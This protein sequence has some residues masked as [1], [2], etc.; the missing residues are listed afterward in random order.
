MSQVL[1][2]YTNTRSC[3]SA[4]ETALEVES[5]HGPC[6]FILALSISPHPHHPNAGQLCME[7]AEWAASYTT[8]RCSGGQFRTH[9]RFSCRGTEYVGVRVNWRKRDG[10]SGGNA[11]R[12]R[13][14]GRLI[15]NYS[16]LKY[17]WLRW[18]PWLQAW[19]SSETLTWI[20]SILITLWRRCTSYNSHTIGETWPF[21]KHLTASKVWCGLNPAPLNPGAVL[22]VHLCMI[23]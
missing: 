10:V 3:Y 9:V 16:V 18:Q 21:T 17:H 2:G 14:V 4:D 8:H 5:S 19:P 11:L 7:K 22:P 12:L 15:V 1:V 13:C 6:C 23:F 20:M